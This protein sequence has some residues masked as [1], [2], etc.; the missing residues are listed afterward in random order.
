MYKEAMRTAWVEIDLGALRRNIR[1]IRAKVGKKR[2]IYGVI[3]ADGYGHGAVECAR[4]L[5]EEGVHAFAVATIAEA[6]E[7][8]HAGIRDEILCLGLTVGEH[9]DTIIQYDITPVVDDYKSAKAL[10]AA[11]AESTG[12]GVPKIVRCVLAADTGM[13]RIGWM[14]NNKT[15]IA[16]AVREIKKIK[17]LPCLEIAGI[18]SHF[19]TA[20]ESDKDFAQLQAERFHL[21]TTAIEEAGIPLPM[22]M[23]ANSAA[24]MELP[25]ARFDA[26]RPGIILYGLYPSEDVNKKSL[27]LKPVMSVKASIIKVKKVP[28]GYSCGYGR[29]FVAAR[30][31]VIATIAIGY[32]D[33]Y[34]RPYSD[35]AKVIVGGRFAPIAG[36]ICMD[37]CMIDVTDI[38]GVKVRDEVIV[39]GSAP[40]AADGPHAGK[41]LSISADDIAKAT[42]TINYEITCGF[43]QRLPKIYIHK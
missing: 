12:V 23:M 5:K 20:D 25:E 6:I 37:M 24:I 14:C 43:G 8:R 27:K 18:F 35:A 33:G 22:K 7:L 9:A 16:A 42:G 17:T 29:K 10:S 30:P 28:K 26:V 36:S 3:K 21:L 31:S 15:N 4:V 19:A 39:V 41:T 40:A 13:G 38:P 32:A 34:P 11:A 1:A 2:K